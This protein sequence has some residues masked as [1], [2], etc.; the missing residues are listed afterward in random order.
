MLN[1]KYQTKFKSN[2]SINRTLNT[3]Y[4]KIN[5]IIWKKTKYGKAP[6]IET[7]ISEI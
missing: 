6:S 1:L 2:I 5:Q 7:M 3:N 4:K